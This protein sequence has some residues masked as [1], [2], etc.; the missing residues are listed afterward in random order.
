MLHH[1]RVKAPPQSWLLT[2]RASVSVISLKRG[3]NRKWRWACSKE[4]PAL[5]LE[6][7]FYS[8]CFNVMEASDWL[9]MGFRQVHTEIYHAELAFQRRSQSLPEPLTPRSDL[10][11][12]LNMLVIGN[13]RWNPTLIRIYYY[14]NYSLLSSD[15]IQDVFP[16][17]HTFM[18]LATAACMKNESTVCRW[19]SS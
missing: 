9:L 11:S 12:P 14:S 15:A 16:F 3:G 17:F 1:A 18:S 2:G 8:D 7:L 4:A 13:C 19:R 10:C 6:C 5:R